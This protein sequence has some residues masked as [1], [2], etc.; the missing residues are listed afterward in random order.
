MFALSATLFHCD[1]VFVT[2]RVPD[3][4]CC[5][6]NIH[7]AVSVADVTFPGRSLSA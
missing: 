7:D 5:G 1:V 6:C 4:L 3:I 2:A